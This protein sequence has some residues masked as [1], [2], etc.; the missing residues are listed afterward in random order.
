MHYLRLSQGARMI[1]IGRSRL[2]PQSFVS[3]PCMRSSVRDEA[4]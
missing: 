4:I 2:G 3:L 1:Q